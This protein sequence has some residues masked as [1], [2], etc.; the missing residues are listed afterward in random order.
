M[1]ALRTRRVKH[2]KTV[3]DRINATN[4][5]LICLLGDFVTVDAFGGNVEPEELTAELSRLRAPAGVV[6][7]LGNHDH[8]KGMLRMHDALTRAGI[9]VLEDTAVSIVTPSGP[10]W[11]V[12]VSDLWSGK[13]D[14]KRAFGS[15][16]SGDA[17]IIVITH[18]PDMFPEVPKGVL[19]T[20]AGHTHGGQVRLPF[21]G[22]PIVPSRYGQRY[23]MGHIQEDGRDLFVTTGVGTS[24]I[25][26]RFGVP[27]V[28]SVLTISRAAPAARSNP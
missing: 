25:P 16:T 10:L 15:I 6:A 24:G 22:S 27:P 2:L 26:V 19:L 8:A 12:G 9:R 1:L 14:V 3:V 4:P 23:V 13:H 5:D 20:L 11:I 7:V 17:P 18:N 21:I 28:I